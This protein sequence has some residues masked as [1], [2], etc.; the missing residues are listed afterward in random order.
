MGFL[1]SLR[2]GVAAA[3]ALLSSAAEYTESGP[4]VPCLWSRGKGFKV[5]CQLFEAMGY[6]LLV[7]FSSGVLFWYANRCVVVCVWVACV[8]LCQSGEPLQTADFTKLP[9]A[10]QVLRKLSPNTPRPTCLANCFWLSHS[11]RE[12]AAFKFLEC[13]LV[14]HACMCV[15]YIYIYIYT[16]TSIY[17]HTQCWK[18]IARS[19]HVL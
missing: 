3:S 15:Y 10:A 2:A 18:C 19:D 4:C 1:Q 5:S 12:P 9:S 7:D 6:L 14:V 13:V 11:S 16:H 8:R 17:L